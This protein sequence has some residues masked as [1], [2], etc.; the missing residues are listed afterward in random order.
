[1][2]CREPK[3]KLR[4][5]TEHHIEM[6]M[7][8]SHQTLEEVPLKYPVLTNIISILFLPQTPQHHTTLSQSVGYR[9]I[10]LDTKIF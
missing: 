8:E 5:P 3:V 9:K 2:C 6:A 4:S 1:M 10:Y 7:A